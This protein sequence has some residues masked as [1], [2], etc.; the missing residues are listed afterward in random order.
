MTT[1]V[2]G[3][4][5]VC[6]ACGGRGYAGS[7][8]PHCEFCRPGSEAVRLREAMEDKHSE[9]IIRQRDLIMDEYGIGS[10]SESTSKRLWGLVEKARLYGGHVT[11]TPREGGGVT[12]GLAGLKWH[13]DDDAPDTY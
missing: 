4:A 11:V 13:P 10:V 7:D 9:D 12:M 5:R 3:T 1:K 2:F 8:D 6:E